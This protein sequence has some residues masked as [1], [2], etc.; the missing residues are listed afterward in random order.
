MCHR[1]VQNQRARRKTVVLSERLNNVIVDLNVSAF[2]S[3][4][5]CDLVNFDTSNG[6]GLSL[7]LSLAR[8]LSLSLVTDTTF[9]WTPVLLDRCPIERSI[10]RSLKV[11]DLPLFTCQKKTSS[12]DRRL[13]LGRWELLSCRKKL[14]GA[15]ATQAHLQEQF[16]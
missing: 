7:S 9:Y 4:C 6:L 8:S 14:S 15:A 5:W 13:D 1:K 12:V 16:F 10:K 11:H 3:Y 2:T